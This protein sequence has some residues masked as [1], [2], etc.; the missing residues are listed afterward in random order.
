[1]SFLYDIIIELRHVLLRKVDISFIALLKYIKL[2]TGPLLRQRAGLRECSGNNTR[3]TELLWVFL[4]A[5]DYF[6]RRF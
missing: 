2:G 5:G 6:G 3:R 1:M 4:Y